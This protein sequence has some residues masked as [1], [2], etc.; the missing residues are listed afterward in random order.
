[1]TTAALILAAIAVLPSDRMVM[2]DRL[3]N[4]GAYADAKAEYEALRGE[5]EIAA[6]ELLFRLAECSRML[7]DAAA[8][9]KGFDELIGS[10]PT[11]QYADRS[12][13]LKALSMSGDGRIS[14]LKVLDSDRVQAAIRSVA[15]YHLGVETNDP[16]AL[17]RCC[18]IDP[19]GRYAAYAN[20]RRAAILAKSKDAMERRKALELL[21]GIAFGKNRELAEEAL[22]LAGVQCYNEKRYGEAVSLLNRF[23]K[24]YP[25][26]KHAGDVRTMAV[27]S[28]YLS[29]KYADAIALAGDG[30]TD[31]AAY[32]R[33]ASAYANGDAKR[34]VE[35]F[36][37]YLE[38]W[39]QGKYRTNAELPLARIGFDE[40]EKSGDVNKA[41]EC[42]GR[43]YA[44]SKQAGDS[45]RLAWAYERNGLGDKAL[46]QYLSV[47]K[48][49]P[50]SD[51][52]AEA[53]YRKAMLDLREERW[54]AAELSLAE[55][56]ASGRNPR[57]KG[58]S[59][60]WRGIACIKLAHPEEGVKHL[61]EALA[62]G[63]SVDQSREARIFIADADL[64]AGRTDVAREAYRVLVREGACDR[65][66][67]A[68]IREVGLLV[69]GAEAK[70][71]AEA[72]IKGDSSQWRQAGYAM[73]GAEQE[74][75]GEFSAAIESYRKC[76]AEDAEVEAI[77]EASLH[78][79]VLEAKAGDFD[80]ARKTLTRAVSLNG[81]SPS[82]R[83]QAY[84]ALAQTCEQVKD[85]TN[86]CAYATV[87]V[88]LFDDEKLCGEAKRILAAHPEVAK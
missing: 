53:L 54:S 18:R 82:A 25:D 11:S 61:R 65:L 42:A 38:D 83:A 48:D 3:F 29:G 7:G 62:T 64:R 87:V 84:V 69:G 9:A 78:L 4:R 52:A 40:A 71:C 30:A 41:V 68:K 81:A 5:K 19:K 14:E 73:L 51:D 85:Y 31:D 74:K 37:K 24:A 77:A 46:A 10:H 20:F 70:T 60:Y 49:Y 35:L 28:C 27:W 32:V 16:D 75:A 55:A 12:R 2:A 26:G 1:M 6:D 57:R 72:L 79:G 34:S 58:E 8:A 66:S 88:S 43:A 22:Y 47:A 50:R 59:L 36:R 13:L 86:A 76:L 33:A 63:L 39:P 23:L 67:A 15:L 45:L 21:L 80:A 56:L 17:E 44:L